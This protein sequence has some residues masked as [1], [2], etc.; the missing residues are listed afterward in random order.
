MSY[1]MGTRMKEDKP[2]HWAE[3]CMFELLCV[4][5][6]DFID[7]FHFYSFLNEL[8]V[9]ISFHSLSHFKDFPKHDSYSW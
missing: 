9:S 8:L 7:N 1:N 4:I 2:Y 6:H 5:A 3:Y